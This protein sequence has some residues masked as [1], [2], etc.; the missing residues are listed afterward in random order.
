MNQRLESGVNSSVNTIENAENVNYLDY[1]NTNRKSLVM[2]NQLETETI[3]KESE[4]DF[5]KNTFFNNTISFKKTNVDAI[6]VDNTVN[7]LEKRKISPSLTDKKKKTA[8]EEKAKL[9]TLPIK[10]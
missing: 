3:I 8:Q 5:T 1:Y 4:E 7:D 9:K 6:N 2:K 10:T